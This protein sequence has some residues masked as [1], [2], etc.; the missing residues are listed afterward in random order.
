MVVSSRPSGESPHRSV[1]PAHAAILFDQ[2]S[3]TSQ[4]IRSVSFWLLQIRRKPF[5]GGSLPDHRRKRWLH[6]L[7]VSFQGGGDA[8]TPG[9]VIATGAPPTGKV[10]GA[11]TPHPTNSRAPPA[12]PLG[13][14]PVASYIAA[15]AMQI[16]CR[17]TAVS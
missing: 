15:I 17:S 5:F 13:G 8:P 14:T 2:W 4:E 12:F 16:C 11:G 10:P 7:M 1:D 3:L 6:E 9:W